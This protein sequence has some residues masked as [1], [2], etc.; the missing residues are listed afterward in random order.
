[1]R[2][3]NRDGVLQLVAE[4]DAGREAAPDPEDRP[5]REAPDRDDEAWSD[6]LELP[7]PPEGAEL[8]LAWR[9]RPVATARG[10]ASGIATRHRGAVERP[11]E[12]VLVELEPAAQSLAGSSPPGSALGALDD[13]GCLAV[14]V[15]TLVQV[16]VHDRQRVE[17]E[18]GLDARTAHAQVALERSE[19]AVRRAPPGQAWATRNQRP[20]KSSR[21]PS[22]RAR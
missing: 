3:W 19:G 17:W 21:P 12:V 6:Q 13:P 4:A 16:L 2:E 15:R 14:H 8:L 5:D 1:M 18:A 11:V 22:S 7:A 10:R 9:R 20:L